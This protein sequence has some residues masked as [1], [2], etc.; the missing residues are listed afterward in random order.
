MADRE[1]VD[2][3][4]EE[5]REGESELSDIL[6][7]IVAADAER[8]AVAADIDR[9]AEYLRRFANAADMFDLPAIKELAGFFEANALALGDVSPEDRGHVERQSLFAEW[10]RLLI[11]FLAKPDDGAPPNVIL[12]LADDL[13]WNGLGCYGSDL[14]EDD[15][16]L[17]FSDDINPQ[18]VNAFLHEAPQHVNRLS[19]CIQRIADNRA[20]ID[21]I[22][23]AQRAAHTIK[24]SAN[25]TGVAGIANLTHRLE[26]ILEFFADEERLPPSGLG[27]T[28]LDA[29]DCLEMMVEHL[30]GMGAYLRHRQAAR[31]A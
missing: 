25:I 29:S 16:R 30:L 26:D 10:P 27:E 8:S 3:L 2:A 13:G 24:G 6:S 21:E 19:Q 23:Q 7:G 5:L 20:D 9:Y 31:I 18:L 12:F 15:V 4:C 17:G 28:L 14:H 11:G 1:V 22:S